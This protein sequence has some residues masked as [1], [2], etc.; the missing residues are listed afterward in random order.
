MQQFVAVLVA[1]D[2][3]AVQRNPPLVWRHSGDGHGSAHTLPA[4]ETVAVLG[5]GH[6]HI[7][8]TMRYMHLL[9]EDLQRPHEG[10][11]ILNRLR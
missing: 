7:S 3:A 5:L 1:Q 4:N 11:S 9:T 8:T 6:A 2:S 10:L